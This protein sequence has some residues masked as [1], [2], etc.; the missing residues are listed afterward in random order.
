M[1]LDHLLAEVEVI[2]TAVD[3]VLEV[4]LEEVVHLAEEVH[5]LL[6]EALEEDNLLNHAITKNTYEN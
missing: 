1:L 5:H 2:L 6:V 3:L 4:T